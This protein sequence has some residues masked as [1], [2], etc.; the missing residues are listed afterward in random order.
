MY[1]RAAPPRLRNPNTACHFPSVGFLLQ[2][3]HGLPD[4]GVDAIAGPKS[5]TQSERNTVQVRFCRSL[6]LSGGVEGR[7]CMTIDQQKDRERLSQ[8][9]FLKWVSQDFQATEL[10]PVYWHTPYSRSSIAVHC[11]LIP[12][13]KVDQVL[14]APTW[15]LRYNDGAP[16]SMEYWEHGEKKIVTYLRY[17][18]DDRLEPLVIHRN[19]NGICEDYAEVSEEFRLFHNLCHDRKTNKYTKIDD[20]GNETEVIVI[21][22]DKVRIRLKEIRQFLAVKEMHLAVFFDNREH[23]ILRLNELGLKEGGQDT[24]DGLMI[25]GLYYGDARDLLQWNTFSRLLGKRLFTPFPKDKSGFWGFGVAE[26]VKH[27]DFIIDLDEHGDEV[28]STSD[29][30]QLDN[31]FGANPGR[32]HYL[33]PVFFRKTVLDKYYQQSE[34]YSVED[35][36]LRCCGLWGMTMDNHHDEYVVAWLG[37][38]GRDLPHTEQLHWRSFNVAPCG[39]VSEV[40]FRRQILAQWADTG[41]PDLVL[42]H[43]FPSFIHKCTERLGWSLFLPLAS[44]DE[45]FF[46][47]LRIPSSNEQKELDELVQGLAKVLVDSLN[48]KQLLRYIPSDQRAGLTG[49]ISRLERVLAALKVDGYEEHIQFLRDLQDLRSSGSAHRKYR[50]VAERFAIDTTQLPTV[51]REMIIKSL[52]L[53]LFLEK[54]VVAGMFDSPLEQESG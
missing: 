29:E 3:A 20:A 9:E 4:Q 21:E 6:Y 37:D 2:F 38:L 26:P 34:K 18:N 41:Q 46:N 16:G 32:P 45:H 52:N 54:A 27:V 42:K 36:Y 28:L 19:F 51:F 39:N 47:S 7:W 44:K 24:R 13:D 11:A 48:E 8:A 49:S 17:G 33:T 15:D 5:E 22:P 12:C 35:S 25:Y 23:S 10:I 1:R 30:D 40:F 53:I 14:Q 31:N 50:S 43:Q